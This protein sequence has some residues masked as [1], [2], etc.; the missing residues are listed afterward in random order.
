MA[1]LNLLKKT[2]SS[3]SPTGNLKD[4]LFSSGVVEARARIV[5]TI[6]DA[7]QLKPGEIMVASFTEYWLDPLLQYY[8][9]VDHG[10]WQSRFR[11]ADGGVAREYRIP[12]SC[13]GKGA[14]QFPEERGSHPV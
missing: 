10:D 9:R 4:C 13:R 1:F 5:H 8:C 6:E 3:K 14:R 7:G 2:G 12:A 11:M